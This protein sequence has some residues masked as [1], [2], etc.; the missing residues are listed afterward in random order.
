MSSIS[1]LSLT[2][3]S[4]LP[5][6]IEPNYHGKN[7]LHT[8]EQFLLKNASQISSIENSL[9]SLTFILPG[10][11][12][13]VEVMSEAIYSIL[14]IIGIYHDNIL[15]KASERLAAY[16]Q[17]FRASAHNR[18]T[19]Y[20][21]KHNKLYKY[22]SLLLAVTRYTEILWE[23]ASKNKLGEKGRWALVFFL[24][25]LKSILRFVLVAASKRPLASPSVV[26]REVDPQQLETRSQFEENEFSAD[27]DEKQ[28][29]V[30][31]NPISTAP[32][33]WKLPR[34]GNYIPVTIPL[35]IDEFLSG[36]VLTVEDVKSPIELF[37]TLTIKGYF[38][39]AAYILRPLVYC[40][41][42]YRYRDRPRNWTPWVVGAGM[43]YLARRALVDSFKDS[44]P[45]GLRSI[46][47][48]EDKELKKRGGSLWWWTLRGAMY[49]TMTRPIFEKIIRKTENIP[50]VNLPASILEDYEYLLDNYHFASST[51]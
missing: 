19:M 16:D 7:W 29:D 28:F 35:K 8:Y 1:R 6:P 36:K 27:E 15:A 42:A 47:Q 49:H 20:I 43:E 37:H 10:R 22:V 39:E 44:L 24:E 38:S 12:K 50:L 26:E 4:K 9:R 46:T 14:Q 45:G 32:L 13:D 25:S 21:T 34:S 2:D 5:K 17:D 33:A 3:G 30:D 48:L 41:L 18:Y 51:L 23:M 31:G 40:T 11:Y